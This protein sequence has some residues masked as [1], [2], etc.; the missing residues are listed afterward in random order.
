MID[1]MEIGLHNSRGVMWRGPG[2]RQERNLASKYRAFSR[3]L[4]ADYPVTARMLE[5]VAQMYDGQAEWH[6][7]DEAVRERLQRR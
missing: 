7:T 2:G 5:R 3:Q 6:D 1:G 4:Q